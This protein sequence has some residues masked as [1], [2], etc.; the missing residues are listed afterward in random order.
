MAGAW[1]I[2]SLCSLC[3]CLCLDTLGTLAAKAIGL[4]FR[5]GLFRFRFKASSTTTTASELLTKVLRVFFEGGFRGAQTGF[6]DRGA[7]H[8]C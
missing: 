1:I 7:A 3:L 5:L 4:G 6:V 2:S 8:F